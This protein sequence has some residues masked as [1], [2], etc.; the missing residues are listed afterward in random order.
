[1]PQLLT[2]HRH[3][4]PGGWIERLEVDVI[5][6][7]DDDT[8]PSDSLLA[9]IGQQFIDTA[10]QTDISSNT[11]YTMRGMIEKAGFINVHEKRTK[12]PIGPWARHPIYKSAGGANMMSFKVG[13]EG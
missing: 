12:I 3:I 10:E 5:V 9:K 13:I 7:C 1:M 2:C 6:R 4:A 11:A 8:M